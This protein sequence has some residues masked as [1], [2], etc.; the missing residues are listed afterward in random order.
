MM[1]GAHCRTIEYN[2]HRFR[3]GTDELIGARVKGRL[4]HV[5]R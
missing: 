4:R 3:H 5:G 2:I 1:A